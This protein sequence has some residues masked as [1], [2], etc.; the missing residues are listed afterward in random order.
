MKKQSYKIVVQ[1]VSYTKLADLLTS[2][3][4]PLRTGSLK[5]SVYKGKSLLKCYYVKEYPFSC[6]SDFDA[7][8]GRLFRNAIVNIEVLSGILIL[9]VTCT[10]HF[11]NEVKE[12]PLQVSSDEFFL[13]F[14]EDFFGVCC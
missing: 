14:H 1:R 12:F 8:L 9:Y 13:S 6:P 10:P 2:A 3:S 5:I 11:E 7:F 4:N